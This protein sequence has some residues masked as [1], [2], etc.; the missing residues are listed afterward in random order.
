MDMQYAKASGQLWVHASCLR[1]TLKFVMTQLSLEGGIDVTD[2]YLLGR[3]ADDLKRTQYLDGT[4]EMEFDDDY[5]QKDR[6]V[7]GGKVKTATGYVE[8]PTCTDKA[9]FK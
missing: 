3:V 2:K 1:D 6:T 9:D 5:R 7:S 4:F 8:E